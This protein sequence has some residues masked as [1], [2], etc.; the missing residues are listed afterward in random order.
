ML[1]P[2]VPVTVGKARSPGSYFDGPWDDDLEIVSF[3]QNRFTHDC[4]VPS[5]HLVS[6]GNSCP[7]LTHSPGHRGQGRKAQGS[8]R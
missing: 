5:R 1:T 8:W 3:R 6:F 4:S 7:R 2:H